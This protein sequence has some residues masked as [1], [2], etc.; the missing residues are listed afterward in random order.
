MTSGTWKL[1]PMSANVTEQRDP[2]QKPASEFDYV[3]YC[4]GSIAPVRP[5][6]NIR[7]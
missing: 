1:L 4:R 2:R 7:R 5:L 3:A 6:W